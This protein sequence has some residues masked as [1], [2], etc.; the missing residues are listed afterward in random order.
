LYMVAL[1]LL[2]SILLPDPRAGKGLLLI[3]H[4]RGT[5]TTGVPQGTLAASQRA[6]AS[7]QDNE[8]ARPWWSTQRETKRVRRAGDESRA[9]RA[10]PRLV[11]MLSTD[12]M[13]G[14]SS[15]QCAVDGGYLFWSGEQLIHHR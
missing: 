6:L 14:W 9:M 1:L 8:R 5:K 2:R 4:Y 11:S 12:R 10:T 13:S 7:E 3:P 15:A